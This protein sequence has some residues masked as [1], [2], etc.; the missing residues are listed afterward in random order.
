MQNGGKGGGFLLGSVG[1][2]WVL[3]LSRLENVE[4]LEKI[5]KEVVGF[6]SLNTFK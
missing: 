6:P 2:G 3:S 5:T 1:L 4:P